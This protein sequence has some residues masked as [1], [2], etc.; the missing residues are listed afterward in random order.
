[1]E[2]E[3]KP[4]VE[5]L[6]N[7]SIEV[8]KL[9]ESIETSTIG[10][11]LIDTTSIETSSILEYLTNPAY[12]SIISKNKKNKF[13]NKINKEELK[14][15]RKRIIALTKDMLKGAIPSKGLKEM[16]DDYVNSIIKYFK[17]VD[18]TD[19]IQNQYN[20]SG[21]ESNELKEH[22]DNDDLND[23]ITES[24][25]L[26][27]ANE[28]IMKKPIINSNLNNFVIS[29]ATQQAE[30]RIIPVKLE[31]DLN[32]PSLKTKGIKPKKF[33]KAK[34]KTTEEDSFTELLI[35]KK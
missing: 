26:D 13:N 23:I 7:K 28:L 19:I 24:L 1:M 14:F 20:D 32:S 18:K 29:T 3:I 12:H 2:E 5:V 16:H 34:T 33:K 22:D 17:I 8:E 21:E 31:I 6:P 30:T 9:K 25:T 35:E 4:V 15:Y 10:K 11:S 27:E